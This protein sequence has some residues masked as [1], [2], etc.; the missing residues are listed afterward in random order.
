MIRLGLLAAV[1]WFI[2]DQA[3]KW[4]I[5]N[6]VMVPPRSGPNRMSMREIVGEEYM[7]NACSHAGSS[8]PSA[9]VGC[10]KFDNDCTTD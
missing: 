9:T 4:W 5:V 1:S 2:V 10:E 7:T 8:E 6:H 3:T